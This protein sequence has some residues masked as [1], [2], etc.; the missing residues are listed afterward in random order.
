MIM[1]KLAWQRTFGDKLNLGQQSLLKQ[2]NWQNKTREG[3]REIQ[4]NWER[5]AAEK[6]MLIAIVWKVAILGMERKENKKNVTKSVCVDIASK[7]VQANI[8]YFFNQLIPHGHIIL[9]LLNRL[10]FSLHV[11]F[12]WDQIRT[13]IHIVYMGDLALN[14]V[15]RI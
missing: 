4:H 12:F 15:I 6:R 9:E 13:H 8:H 3:E 5:Q 2:F 14:D 7:H 10:N 11:T 1:Q